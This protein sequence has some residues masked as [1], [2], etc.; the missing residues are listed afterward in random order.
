MRQRT[1]LTRWMTALSC[2]VVG[3]VLM[4]SSVG[5]SDAR[6]TT[7]LTFSGP[8]QLPGVTLPAGTYIFERVDATMDAGVI[9]VLSR[10]RSAVYA[11]MRTYHVQR[12]ADGSRLVFWET[13]PGTAP[14]V[15]AWYPG[16]G[17]SG[18]QFIYSGAQARPLA[19]GAL[20]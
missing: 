1:G 2:A 5:A 13:R 9:H 20:D 17:R 10:N 16:G 18:H 11:M 8:F 4:V 19:S 12:S 7:Y 3:G 14:A 15:R 6:H